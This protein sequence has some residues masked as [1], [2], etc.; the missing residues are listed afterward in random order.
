MLSI[1]SQVIQK[2]IYIFEGKDLTYDEA[3]VVL[4]FVT[5]VLNVMSKE[6]YIIF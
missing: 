1:K 2:I 5:K 3:E 4:D 6:N